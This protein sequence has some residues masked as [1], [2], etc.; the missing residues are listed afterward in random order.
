[1]KHGLVG[2]EPQAIVS[3]YA[4]Y[5]GPSPAALTSRLLERVAATLG[6]LVPATEAWLNILGS[7]LFPWCEAV[8]PIH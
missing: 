8:F 4:S 6:R 2:G 1:M 7:N 5:Y 3:G